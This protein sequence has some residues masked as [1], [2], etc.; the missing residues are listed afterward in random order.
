MK[1]KAKHRYGGEEVLTI[2]EVVRNQVDPICY[3]S[4]ELE[5]LKKHVSE[6][7]DMVVRIVRRLPDAA[8]IVLADELGYTWERE[9]K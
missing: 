7:Q 4:G 1:Y 6:L 3:D 5:T 2:E 9:Q 8:Q